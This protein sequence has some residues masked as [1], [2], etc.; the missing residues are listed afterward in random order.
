MN[1]AV[2]MLKCQKA[3]ESDWQNSIDSSPVPVIGS[4]FSLPKIMSEAHS[5]FV[6]EFLFF[7]VDKNWSVQQEYRDE[8]KE[9]R[10]CANLLHRVCSSWR[11]LKGHSVKITG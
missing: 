3:I 11:T 5:V 1:F 10:H 7:R 9:S 2:A 6:K 4:A 8:E